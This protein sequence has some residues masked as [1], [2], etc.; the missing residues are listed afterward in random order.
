MSYDTLL[1]VRKGKVVYEAHVSDITSHGF[2]VIAV[3]DIQP[4]DLVEISL[5]AIGWVVAQVR[6]SGP[7]KRLGCKFLD[8][9]DAAAFRVCLSRMF[10]DERK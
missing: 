7:D 5:P 3:G 6:W 8:P 10:A 4:R 1:T 9:L 2:M